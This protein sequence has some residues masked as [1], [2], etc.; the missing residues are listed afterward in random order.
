M[1]LFL[2]TSK[3]LYEKLFVS[4]FDECK[5]VIDI[6]FIQATEKDSLKALVQL[7][8][9]GGVPENINVYFESE[10]P[11]KSVSMLHSSRNNLLLHKDVSNVCPVEV[12]NSYCESEIQRIGKYQVLEW[13]LRNFNKYI[14]SIFQVTFTSDA[15][16]TSNDDFQAY[17][18]N[19]DVGNICRV[20]AVSPFNFWAWGGNAWLISIALI[21]LM[22]LL[23]ALIFFI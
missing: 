13:R 23:T 3:E 7:F 8:S 14:T 15:N 6:D 18:K 12:K 9:Y 4:W 20:E 11:M 17:I 5:I 2:T 1:T 22:T 16:Y 19:P 21:F 10:L